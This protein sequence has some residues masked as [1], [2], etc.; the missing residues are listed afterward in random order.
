MTG[1]NDYLNDSFLYALS[2]V[3]SGQGGQGFIFPIDLW[4]WHICQNLL[5][6]NKYGMTGCNDYLN[7]SFLDALS[8]VGG[9]QV[10][11]PTMTLRYLPKSIVKQM[12]GMTECNEYLNDQL[13]WRSLHCWRWPGNAVGSFS[14]DLWFSDPDIFAKN[15][16]LKPL[17]NI[18][19]DR[20]K[21]F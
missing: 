1:C 17:F 9:A 7:D 3:R 5:L 20:F 4:P 19:V 21:K 18:V 11:F 10:Q 8:V 6:T 15:L 14:P 13:S 12:Y 16:L 2:V